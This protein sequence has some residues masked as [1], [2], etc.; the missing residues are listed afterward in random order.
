MPIPHTPDADAM[1]TGATPPPSHPMEFITPTA[2]ARRSAGTTSC[3]DAQM[4]ASYMPLKNPNPMVANTNTVTLNVHPVSTR[5]GTPANTRTACFHMRPRRSF[6]T[7]PSATIPPVRTPS[8]DAAC[9]YAVALKPAIVKLMWKVRVR[10]EGRHVRNTM[11][12]KLAQMKTAISATAMGLRNT[13]SHA[14]EKRNVS[15][16]KSTR[17]NYS[18]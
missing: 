8:T 17:L 11:D 5:N 1:A 14:P 10:Y 6:R 9:R 3:S 7:Q 12:T 4:L 13:S 2:V 16:R 15:D 18:H